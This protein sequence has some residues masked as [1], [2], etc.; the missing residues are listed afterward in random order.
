MARRHEQW[1][2]FRRDVLVYAR[3]Q[4]GRLYAPVLHPDLADIPAAHGVERMELIQKSLPPG[5]RTMLDIGAHWG[6]FCHCFETLGYKCTAVENSDVNLHFLHRLRRA[7]KR[8]FEVKEGS[9]FDCD[10]RGEYDVVL[11]L[12]IFHHF[13]KEAHLHAAL[14]KF[15]TQLRAKVLFFEPHRP[16]ELQMKGSFRNYGFEEFVSFVKQH[17]RFRTAACIGTAEDSRAVYKLER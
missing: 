8:T 2:S 3:R 4:G 9:I 15:L 17:G 5:S 12:N 11:A 13:T 10:L 1:A 7:E 14:I 16:T 6:Y